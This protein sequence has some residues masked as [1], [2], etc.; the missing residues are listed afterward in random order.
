LILTF[1]LSLTMPSITQ[2]VPAN[3]LFI[4]DLTAE[5]SQRTTDGKIVHAG[6]LIPKM[7][8]GSMSLNQNASLSLVFELNPYRL[9]AMEKLR[10]SKDLQL[11]V[12]LFCNAV[13]DM[14]PKARNTLCFRI[15]LRIPKSD[16]AETYLPQLGFKT[17]SLIE[18]PQPI[19]PDFDETISYLN[20]A[21]KQYSMGEYHRVFT[22]C[23]KAKESL[24]EKIK[25]KGFEKEEIQDGKKIMVPDWD[26]FFDNE[27]LGDAVAVIS[28]KISR[29]TSTGAHPG[30][31]ICKEDADFALMVTH[32]MINLVVRKFSQN[33]N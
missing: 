30:R 11:V 5:L 8:I 22:D 13:F 24:A 15:E 1:E 17:V 25:S 23:R 9:S 2:P 16:W 31:L 19:N 28:K 14:Q 4:S 29:I 27:E 6:Q 10:E 21:W 26:K 32:A 20:D 12:A 7:P 33:C 18:V 3:Q